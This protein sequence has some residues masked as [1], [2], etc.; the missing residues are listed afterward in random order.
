MLYGRDPVTGQGLSVEN[1]RFQLVT[2]L[3]AGHEVSPLGYK[4]QADYTDN[5]RSTII[6]VSFPHP[7][8]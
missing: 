5:I 1:I 4:S 3:I 8:P 6:P 2:F 7:N